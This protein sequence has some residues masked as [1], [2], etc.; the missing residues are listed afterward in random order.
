[1]NCYLTC[2]IIRMAFSLNMSGEGVD[3]WSNIGM[4]SELEGKAESQA[5]AGSCLS[6]IS[7][8][9]I[10]CPRGQHVLIS[11]THSHGSFISISRFSFFSTRKRKSCF[12]KQKILGTC[13]CDYINGDVD[14]GMQGKQ[15]GSTSVSQ[16]FPSFL[17]LLPALL[18]TGVYRLSRAPNTWKKTMEKKSNLTGF[19]LEILPLFWVSSQDSFVHI[20]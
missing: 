14:F 17:S 8:V 7:K 2:E 6:R 1:M 3:P 4:D 5:P 18:L 19:A 16:P 12:S 10:V 9:K 20:G 13:E 11:Q 15:E